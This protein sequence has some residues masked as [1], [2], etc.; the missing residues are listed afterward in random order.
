[1]AKHEFGRM[2][3][4][5]GPERYDAYEPARYHCVAV[6]DGLLDKALP[7]LGELDCFWHTLSRPAKGL[8]YCG[9][10]LI[11]PQSLPGFAAALRQTG[12][13]GFAELIALLERAAAERNFVIHFG[14]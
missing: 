4:P 1:M 12:E 5:P 10:T 14:V 7:A 8:A 3:H 11:P 9:V 2:E 6:E 13:S